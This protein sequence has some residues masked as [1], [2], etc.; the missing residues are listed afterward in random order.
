M[1]KGLTHGESI[2][3]SSN[4]QNPVVQDCTLDDH[5][6]KRNDANDDDCHLT[7]DASGKEA[8]KETANDPASNGC[9]TGRGEPGGRQ[10]PL[11][12]STIVLA[13]VV[14]EG[15]LSNDARPPIVIIS[16]VLGVVLAHIR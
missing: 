5:A 11:L 10:S 3:Q 16:E 2:D 13:I 6:H 7:A 15:S 9:A 14:D 12:S 8:C 4:G 1:D